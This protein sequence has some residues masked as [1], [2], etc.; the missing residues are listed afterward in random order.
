MAQEIAAIPDVVARQP[1]GLAQPLKE[2]IAR[3]GRRPPRVV[4]TRARGS[5]AH[6]ATFG[7]H[8]IERYLGLPVAEAAPSIASVYGQRL[9]L[10][11]QLVLAISQSGKSDDL[12][13]FVD[14]AAASDALTV[15][16]TNDGNSPLATACDITMPIGAGQEL[17]VAATKTFVATVCA[18]LA[19]TALWS[20]NRLLET[21]V[22]RLPQRLGKASGLDW[23]Q[24]IG[25]L[26]TRRAS[27]VTIGR[28]P[29]LGIA[30][31]AALKL[32]E[33]CNLHA[34][35]FSGAEFLHGPVTLVSDQYPVLMF[36]PTDVAAPGMRA[37]A[38]D[39]RMKKTNLFVAEP[40]ENAPGRL[41]AL[42][43]EQPEADALCLVQSF[44]AMALRLAE[45]LGVDVDRPRNLNTITRTT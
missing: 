13:A 33:T 31:E 18:L 12:I 21:A 36:M 23:G 35:A 45:R 37:L 22:Q 43:A 30:R 27:L 26:A 28:G 24:G 41:P 44:Y 17:S 25:A 14:Q 9:D 10:R 38:A 11:D 8:M 16:V 19:L 42:A 40:G 20:R 4:V 34:E 1:E 15:A 32:K 39:L 3:L 6:A 29:T 7:K 5:S 2:L